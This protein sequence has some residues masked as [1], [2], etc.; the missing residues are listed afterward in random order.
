MAGLFGSLP[1]QSAT[2]KGFYGSSTTNLTG[3]G[4]NGTAPKWIPEIFSKNVLMRFKRESVVDAITNTDYFGE[5]ANFGDSV[6]IIK[7]PNISVSSYS[8]G[9]DITST[10]FQDEELILVLDQAHKYQFEVEDIEAKLAHVNWEGLA[11]NAATYNMKMAYNLNVLTYFKDQMLDIQL[12]N[13]AA[14]AEHN[15]ILVRRVAQPTALTSAS[16]AAAVETELKKTA[17]AYTLGVAGTSGTIDPLNYLSKCALYLDKLDVPS[18]GRFMVVPPEFVELL[19]QVE[20]KLMNADFGT[21][22]NTIRNGLVAEDLRGF[23]IYKTNDAPT[24]TANSTDAVNFIIAG[25]TAAVATANSIVKTEKFRS[26]SGFKDVVRGLHV[27]G[28]A[29]VREDCLVGGYVKFEA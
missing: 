28:R 24:L 5:I 23:K 4:G 10:A 14:G 9:E 3:T 7:E 6:K 26:Q 27:F 17:N 2:Q 15:G 13:K 19:S 25:H 12:T 16:D 18:E 8:R 1:T 29:L 20:S 22:P 21:G 11:S